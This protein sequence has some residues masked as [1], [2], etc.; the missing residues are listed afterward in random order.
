MTG[1]M[2]DFSFRCSMH[3]KPFWLV[4]ATPTHHCKH[5]SN[6]GAMANRKWICLSLPE[7]YE[8]HVDTTAGFHPKG[9]VPCT[10][11]SVKSD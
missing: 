2:P 7:G 9:D 6:A 11:I 10:L 3:D 1:V 8:L 4:I 5:F